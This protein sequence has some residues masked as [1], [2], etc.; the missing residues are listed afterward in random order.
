MFYYI[1]YASVDDR[2]TIFIDDIF[3]I[4]ASIDQTYELVPFFP[5]FAEIMGIKPVAHFHI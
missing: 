3:R 1:I 5:K 4:D 2:L